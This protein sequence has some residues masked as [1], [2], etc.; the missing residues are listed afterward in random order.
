MDGDQSKKT[1]D[2]GASA[3]KPFADFAD[4]TLH[5]ATKTKGEPVGEKTT[6]T[7]TSAFDASGAIGKQFTTEGALGGAAQKV[8]G[9]FDAQG[10]IGKQFTTAGSIGGSVQEHLGKGESNSFQK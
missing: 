8:G 3:G 9:P 6:G 4:D 2:S 1:L 7:G 10:A 5:E